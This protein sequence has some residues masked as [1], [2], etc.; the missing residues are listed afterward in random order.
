MY[1]LRL[2]LIIY[3]LAIKKIELSDKAKKEEKKE[4]GGKKA[5]AKK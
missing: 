5:P 3:F 2:S 4:V 1:I